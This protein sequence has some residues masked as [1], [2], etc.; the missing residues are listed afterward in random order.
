[1]KVDWSNLCVLGSNF[2]T[3]DAVAFSATAALA[4]TV[5]I[6]IVI[7]T[8]VAPSGKLSDDAAISVAATSAVL[9]VDA[10]IVALLAV[11]ASAEGATAFGCAAASAAVVVDLHRSDLMDT[12]RALVV[13][14]RMEET[15]LEEVLAARRT[16]MVD[17]GSCCVRKL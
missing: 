3:I 9:D 6:A 16:L 2:G 7:A 12:S 14:R 4:L 13:I 11:D 8:I 5:A 17:K 15:Y 1:M 10:S